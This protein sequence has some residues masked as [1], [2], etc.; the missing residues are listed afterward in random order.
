MRLVLCDDNRILCEALASVLQAHGHRVLA[1]ATRASEG[2]AA[3]STYQP[4]AC[5]LDV[6]FPD[7]SGLDAAR[8][9]R[10]RHPGTKIVVLSCLNDPAVVSEAKKAGVAGF[11]RKDQ[12]TDSIVRAV[13]AVGDGGMAFGP[14]P[15][16][17]QGSR[18]TAEY[19]DNRLWALTPRETEVL[20]RIVAGQ[21]TRQMASEMDVT[22]S[23]L[24]SYIK[25]ILAKLGV[26][27]RLQAAAIATANHHRPVA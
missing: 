1:I 22:I 8:A 24:R 19:R 12:R 27:S 7:G 6:R 16:H 15:P 20:R 11:V 3:V 13:E 10:Q 2:V 17:Q 21:S 14:A 9:M 18:M 26:H 23:T 4:D 5:L 25:S